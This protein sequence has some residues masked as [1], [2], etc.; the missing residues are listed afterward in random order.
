MAKLS[1]IIKSKQGVDLEFIDMQQDE[2]RDGQ[3]I[4]HLTLAK[5]IP[6]VLGR[7]VSDEIS[8][9]SVRLEAN[10]VEMVTI[11]PDDLAHIDAL[12]DKGVPVF[13]WKE[14]GKSGRIK[15]DM[16]LD[17]TRSLEVWIKAEKISKWAANRRK[18]NQD[19]RN[20]ALVSQ[21]RAS[22]TAREFKETDATATGA[23]KDPEPVSAGAAS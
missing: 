20:T 19:K 4:L 15:C 14:E 11:G 21:L 10:D 2:T 3:P 16:T 8:G 17:V 1:E 6:S 12:E 13:E 7:K 18:E 23:K 22:R 5:P 9:D